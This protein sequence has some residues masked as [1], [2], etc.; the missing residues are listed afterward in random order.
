M[1]FR[2]L[3]V[4][5]SAGS[6]VLA[7]ASW[8]AECSY[9][10]NPALQAGR[11]GRGYFVRAAW[12]NEFSSSRR[13]D[14][15]QAVADYLASEAGATVLYNTR[16]TVNDLPQTEWRGSDPLSTLRA[17]AAAA[18]LQVETPTPD[19]WVIGTDYSNE[20]SATVVFARPVDPEKQGFRPASDVG[21]VEKALISQLPVRDGCGRL[22]NCS[23]GIAYYWLPD[24][25]PDAVLVQANVPAGSTGAPPRTKLF[26]V[27][28]QRSTSGV[29]VECMWAS[30]VTGPLLPDIAEDFDRDGVRDFV[31]AGGS[32]DHGTNE[33]LSGRDGHRLLEFVGNEWLVEKTASR[34]GRIA[35]AELASSYSDRMRRTQGLPSVLGFSVEAG[36]FQVIGPGHQ[37]QAEGLPATSTTSADPIDA[38]RRAFAAAVGGAGNARAYV[39]FQGPTRPRF[40]LEQ[41]TVRHVEPQAEIT[42]ELVERGYPARIWFQYKSPTY[43]AEE[44]R[45]KASVRRE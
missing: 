29:K 39:L 30:A 12:P 24:E 25:G 45:R 3:G 4:V 5:F 33:I 35:V 19:L 1:N 21:D 20:R 10:R 16:F 28:L 37:A 31:F 8:G 27:H 43:L 22:R 17:F 38:T 26:R 9:T 13:G 15:Y 6:W 2:A 18:G 14:I 42:P 40:E 36:T 44:E 41:V 32:Y 23:I 34:T 11:D 7:A